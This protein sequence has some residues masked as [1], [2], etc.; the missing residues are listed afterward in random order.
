MEPEPEEDAL[1]QPYVTKEGTLERLGKKK[2]YKKFKMQTAEV[3]QQVLPI[4]IVQT[5]SI[6]GVGTSPI[7]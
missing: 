7:G 2:Q 5:L 4:N 6:V 1:R 3:G